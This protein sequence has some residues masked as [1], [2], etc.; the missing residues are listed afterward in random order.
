[1][2]IQHLVIL[3]G[4]TLFVLSCN[5]GEGLG[6]SSTLEGYIYKI[7]HT[8]DNFSFKKDTFPAADERV[9]LIFGDD[10]YTGDDTRTNHD[11][12]YRFSYLRKGNYT[13]QAFSNPAD[14][15]PE[16]VFT[17]IK[18][19]SGLNVADTIFI[20]DGK[21]Y[22]TAMVKGVVMVQYIKNG[23]PYP[24][25]KLEPAVGTR[26]YIKHKGEETHF[27]DV[28]VGDEGVFIFQKVSPGDYEIYTTSEDRITEL[29][30]TI[31]QEVNVVQTEKT[32]LVPDTFKIFIAV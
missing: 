4:L 22:K 10:Y 5:Q 16:G 14:D 20:H 15:S 3:L 26:V 19:G 18:V 2:K 1:M 6:G 23:W 24:E 28:R 9:N 27:D 8:D 13:V 7:N 12:L 25:E 30:Y 32:Y 31:K 21:A 11:G 29:E 17:T